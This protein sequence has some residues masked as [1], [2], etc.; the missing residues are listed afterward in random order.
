MKLIGS[1]H[2]FTVDIPCILHVKV[3][4]KVTGYSGKAFDLTVQS[5]EVESMDTHKET[6][7]EP[8]K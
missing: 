4:A 7:T 1:L 5:L 2:D 6:A 8:P 3:K